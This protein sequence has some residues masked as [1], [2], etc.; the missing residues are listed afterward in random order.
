MK[1]HWIN[2]RNKYKRKLNYFGKGGRIFLVLFK[3]KHCTNI[4]WLLLSFVCQ[5]R[6][7]PIWVALCPV[8]SWRRDLLCSFW[9]CSGLLLTGWVS[10]TQDRLLITHS[11]PC[12]TSTTYERSICNY[13]LT[14]LRSY[15]HLILNLTKED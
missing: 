3:A 12:L 6:L 15:F 10:L 9:N 8:V 7:G 13:C 5:R 2:F 4:S 1:F 11:H 14:I